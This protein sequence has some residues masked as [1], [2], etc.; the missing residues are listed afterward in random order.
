LGILSIKKHYLGVLSREVSII[1]PSGETLGG[2]YP[3][4]NFGFITATKLGT[5]RS[6]PSIL[7]RRMV[8]R[9][10]PM[11]AWNIKGEK[12]QNLTILCQETILK[13]VI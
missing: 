8:A 13:K 12:I 11:V 6:P 5:R 1:T 9:K 3:T 4:T 7:S 10:N 2:F